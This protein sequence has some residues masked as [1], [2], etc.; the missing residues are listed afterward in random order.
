MR[1]LAVVVVV[2]VL[3]CRVWLA[4]ELLL[5][6]LLTLALLPS[7]CCVVTGWRVVSHL[8]KF[9]DHHF[10]HYIRKLCSKC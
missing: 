7:L 9:S 3:S 5:H 8:V 2:I 10:K 1:D 4:G 6:R